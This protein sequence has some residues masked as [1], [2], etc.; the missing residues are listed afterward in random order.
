MQGHIKFRLSGPTVH[1]LYYDIT[2][3]GH[4]A[5]VQIDHVF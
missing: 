4:V 2:W 5:A 1:S 3:P